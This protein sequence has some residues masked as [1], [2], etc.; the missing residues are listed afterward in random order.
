VLYGGTTSGGALLSIDPA[1]G[2]ATVIGS[3][4]FSALSGLSFVPAGEPIFADGFESGDT[5][6]WSATVG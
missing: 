6:A 4:G 5:S 1:T 3:T 2:A